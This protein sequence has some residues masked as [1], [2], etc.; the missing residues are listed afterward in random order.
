MRISS[1]AV[2]LGGVIPTTS[3]GFDGDWRRWP[4]RLLANAAAVALPL[5]ARLVNG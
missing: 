2:W 4:L 1:R 3:R 5:T